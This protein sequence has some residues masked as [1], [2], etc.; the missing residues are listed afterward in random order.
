MLLNGIVAKDEMEKLGD[1]VIVNGGARAKV[2]ST[3]FTN[4]AQESSGRR[5]DDDT[6][7]AHGH[8]RQRT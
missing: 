8:R 7:K 1:F 2:N 4:I 3:N 5:R 6:K